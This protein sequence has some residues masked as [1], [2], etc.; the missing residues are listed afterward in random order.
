MGSGIR[1]R[2]E[3][4]DPTWDMWGFS[5]IRGTILGVSIIRLIVF[6]GSILG[7]PLFTETTIWRSTGACL[8]QGFKV[9]KLKGR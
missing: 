6:L 4:W 7:S 3:A 1:F 9:S 5:K 2:G 8:L